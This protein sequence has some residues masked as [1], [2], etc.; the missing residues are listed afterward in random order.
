MFGGWSLPDKGAVDD[1]AHCDLRVKAAEHEGNP[2]NS[3]KPAL[4]D[5][6]QTNWARGG[7]QEKWGRRPVHGK[8][9]QID[10]RFISS[11]LVNY[12]DMSN[13][14]KVK[15]ELLETRASLLD[16]SEQDKIRVGL[17]KMKIERMN[18]QNGQSSERGGITNKFLGFLKN[19]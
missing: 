12:Y 3:R 1:R 14:E 13:N 9:I 17:E 19:G 16:M 6:H 7:L 8:I 10:K 11:F 5:Q 2:R 18:Q 4:W 15:L